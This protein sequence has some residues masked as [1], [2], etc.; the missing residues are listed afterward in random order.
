MTL[1]QLGCPNK[2][3]GGVKFYLLVPFITPHSSCFAEKLIDAVCSK[4]PFMTG[5]LLFVILL[6]SFTIFPKLIC[7]ALSTEFCKLSGQK[8]IP[9]LTKALR[10]HTT[11]TFSK[12]VTHAYCWKSKLN[13]SI[14]NRSVGTYFL[15]ETFFSFNDV[16]FEPFWW[17]PP[18]EMGLQDDRL[19]RVLCKWTW[20]ITP[21]FY[22]LGDR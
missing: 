9:V 15:V 3:S 17:A 19:K 21:T 5:H 14:L 10:Y 12:T 1:A 4:I 18:W 2:S 20:L 8:Q 22:Q 7:S 16:V 6:S 13:R 11:Y